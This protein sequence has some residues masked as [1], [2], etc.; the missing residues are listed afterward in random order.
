MATQISFPSLAEDAWVTSPAKIADYMLSHFFLS[1]RSQSYLYDQHVS[2][3]P[4]ILTE[5]QGNI[6]TT[7]SD[8]RQTLETYFSR[9]FNNV[10]VEVSEV[11]NPDSLSK[12]Q[13]TIYIK[14]Y[15]V[16]GKEYVVGKMLQISDTIL[17][18][19]ITLNNG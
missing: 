8:V 13:I 10:V 12:A 9:Y 15:D 6:G 2:S 4:W 16:N 7:I 19:I 1:D 14:F 11:P 17:E 3:L 5:N 18:K